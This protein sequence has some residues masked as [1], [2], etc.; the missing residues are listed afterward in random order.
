MVMMLVTNCSNNS[1]NN[2]EPM[3]ML[4]DAIYLSVHEEVKENTDLIRFF[5]VF[6]INTFNLNIGGIIR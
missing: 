4:N 5:N 3:I 1:V 6:P 2:L